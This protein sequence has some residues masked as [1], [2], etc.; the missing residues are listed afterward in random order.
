MATT[1][2]R[3]TVQI[4]SDAQYVMHDGLE[5]FAIQHLLTRCQYNLHLRHQFFK[6]RSQAM[7]LLIQPNQM[8][9][10]DHLEHGN[11]KGPGLKQMTQSDNLM[12]LLDYVS[13]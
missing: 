10:V 7:E 4:V 1:L 5:L 8:K 6:L 2:W 13:V 3:P 12:S 9:Q 11:T